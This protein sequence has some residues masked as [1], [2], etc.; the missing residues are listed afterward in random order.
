MVLDANA[1]NLTS[2]ETAR[3]ITDLDPLLAAVVVYGHQPSASTR[4]MPAAG[5]ICSAIKALLI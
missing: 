5:A 2:E 3:R 4:S 1:E